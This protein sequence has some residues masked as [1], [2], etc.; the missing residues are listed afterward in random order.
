MTIESKFR[1]Y[2]FGLFIAILCFFPIYEW[3]LKP[4]KSALDHMARGRDA[5]NANKFY[6]FITAQ[7]NFDQKS[8]LDSNRP[9]VY[10]QPSNHGLRLD[11]YGFTNFDAKKRFLATAYDWQSTNNYVEDLQIRF[12][13]QEQPRGYYGQHFESLIDEVRFSIT[14]T[15]N[16]D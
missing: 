4:F 10:T 1:R 16:Q 8:L 13:S 2:V 3:F 14:K 7:I 9:A 6:N 11:V 15:N 12:F 5:E